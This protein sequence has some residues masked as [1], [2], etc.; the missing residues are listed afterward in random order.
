MSRKGFTL[1]ELLVVIAIIAILMAILMPSLRLAREQARGIACR[2]N[3]RQ[4]TYAWMLYR[5]GND[6]DLVGGDPGVPPELN[7]RPWVLQ[8]GGTLEEHKDD[9]RAGSLWPYLKNI[10]V[11]H[12][13]SDRRKNVVGHKNAWRTYSIAGGMNGVHPH[14]GAWE[15]YGYMQYSEIKQPA[16]KIV[17]LAE[18]DPRGYN[19]GSWVLRPRTEQWVDPLGVWHRGNSNAMGFADGHVEMHNFRSSEFMKWN[20]QALHD[21]AGFNFFR[22]PGDADEWADF[23][24]MQR[25]YGYKR[26]K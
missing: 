18:C 5:D 7:N 11:Y 1:I 20:L 26:L 25:H 10:D 17:F 3:I 2:G 9:I 15:I 16:L 8:G 23:E 13:P 24:Y 21:P 19:M 6:D 12:C 4:L 22:T 14:N